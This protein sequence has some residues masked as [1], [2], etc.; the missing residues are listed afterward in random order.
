MVPRACGR[1]FCHGCVEEGVCKGCVEKV[2]KAK[3]KECMV[4]IFVFFLFGGVAFFLSR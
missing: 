3:G 2:K 1:V 4:W